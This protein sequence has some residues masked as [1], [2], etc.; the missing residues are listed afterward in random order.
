MKAFP[1]QCLFQITHSI[2]GEPDTYIRLSGT[3]FRAE[4]KYTK[5]KFQAIRSL[6][7]VWAMLRKIQQVT[8]LNMAKN[9]ELVYVVV[10]CAG[11]EAPWFR[12]DGRQAF[13][14]LVGKAPGSSVLALERLSTRR[15]NGSWSSGLDWGDEITPKQSLAERLLT[16]P[17][18]RRLPL[19]FR[20]RPA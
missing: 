18:R 3:G 8:I 16:L 10:C 14:V 19:N 9:G 15:P 4:F 13:K 20:P 1:D 12:V 6:D 11:N 2:A 17:R 7:E 5:K